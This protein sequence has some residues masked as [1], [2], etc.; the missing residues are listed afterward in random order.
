[1]VVGQNLE[2]ID[3]VEGLKTNTAYKV[4]EFKNDQNKKEPAAI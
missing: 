3:I 4:T 2:P 1:M